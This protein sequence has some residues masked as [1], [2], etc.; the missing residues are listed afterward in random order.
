MAQATSPVPT[1]RR[2]SDRQAE[3]A[4]PLEWSAAGC[5]GTRDD[6]DTGR[7]ELALGVGGGAGARLLA[8]L[9]AGT[10]GL[11]A[12]LG[13]GGVAAHAGRAGLLAHAAALPEGPSC[14]ERDALQ[15]QLISMRRLT[16]Q[17][18]RSKDLLSGLRSQN[19][20]ILN[21][22]WLLPA[23]AT[24]RVAVDVH[25]FTCRVGASFLS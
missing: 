9:R 21:L 16:S 14:L 8:P 6:D 11:Q 24:V 10:P 12:L 4:P 13:H 17:I 22:V 5:R 15:Y 20:L 18:R 1:G 2:A 3:R 7:K 23:S 19:L 25:P